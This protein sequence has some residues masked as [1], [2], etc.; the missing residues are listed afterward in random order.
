MQ[1]LDRLGF[2][3]DEEAAEWRRWFNELAAFQRRA[4]HC[5]PA[6]LAD[7]DTFLLFNWRAPLPNSRGFALLRNPVDL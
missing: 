6:P 5:S 7:G 4:G 1:E 3:F 2:E